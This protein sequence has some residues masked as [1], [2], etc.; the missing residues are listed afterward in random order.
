MRFG[1][2]GAAGQA[3]V[4]D[5]NMHT[6]GPGSPAIEEWQEAGLSLPDLS[7][8]RAARLTRVREQLRQSDV[9]GVLLY[10]PIN[11]RYACDSTNMQVWAMHNAC[12][13]LF[14]ATEGPVILW[15]FDHCEFL[16]SHTAVIDEIR[17]CLPWFYFS[18]GPRQDEQVGRW[19][20]ETADVVQRHGGGN[21]RLAVDRINPEG[22]DALRK[23]GIEVVNGEALM[24]SARHIKTP[25]EITAMRCAV[26]ACET[27]VGVMR[28][29]LVPGVTEQRLWSHLHA[30]NIARGG[31]WIETR[32]LSSGPRTNPWYQECSS[33]PIEAGDLVAF[34]TDLV[35]SYGYMVDTSRTWMCGDGQPSATQRDVYQ[36]AHA[37]IAHNTALLRPGLTYHDLTHQALRY[38]PDEWRHYTLLYHGVGLCDEAP[39][40]YFPP[41]W[42][43]FGYDGVLEPGMVLCVESYVG[44]V[45]GGPGV[46]LED[47]VLITDTGHEV[48]TSLPFEADLLA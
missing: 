12:R 17:P 20:G 42:D 25:D 29:H 31:E 45:D 41:T 11:V 40:I 18:A 9:A 22:V 24:E 36:R 6:L 2:P 43:S 3:M 8:M 34:D 10:D 39:S 37:Q 44:H 13:Y 15:E 19:A 48:L 32:L 21:R 38:D 7:R 23:L 47:Q 4:P 46:K 16:N 26:H 1:R 28:E 33:R 35:G 30:E 14:V 27:A 5:L